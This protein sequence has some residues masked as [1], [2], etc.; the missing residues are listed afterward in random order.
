MGL[1]NNRVTVFLSTGLRI[2]S[3]GEDATG[4]LYVVDHGGGVYRI[5]GTT[6]SEVGAGPVKPQEL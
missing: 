5:T 2:A 3:F 1:V 6:G 4:E